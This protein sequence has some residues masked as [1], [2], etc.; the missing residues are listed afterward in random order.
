MEKN[1]LW[2]TALKKM[3]EGN[4]RFVEDKMNNPNH[5]IIL[6]NNLS[7]EQHPWAI[8]L[9][10]AD[11]RVV[12]EM[13]FDTGLGDLFVIRIAGNVANS[14]TIASIEYAVAHLDVNLIIVMG[15]QNCGAITAAIQGGDAGSAHLNHLVKHMQPALEVCGAGC[16]I[17]D[18]VKKNAELTAEELAAKSEIIQ[19]E[20]KNGELKVFSAYYHLDSGKVDFYEEA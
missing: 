11:S 9:S 16:G 7:H 13:A 20:I 12:P 2:A 17:N 1:L 18:V 15:H 6:R 4:D 5:D 10:C 14:S 19:N 3:K 8:V